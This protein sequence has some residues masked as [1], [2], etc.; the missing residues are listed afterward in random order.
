MLKG[1]VILST[2]NFQAAIRRG[3]RLGSMFVVKQLTETGKEMVERGVN[4]QCDEI[5][6]ASNK[7]NLLNDLHIFCNNENYFGGIRLAVLRGKIQPEQIEI[8][9]FHPD[10]SCEQI[11]IDKNAR[12]ASMPI[13][14]FDASEEVL[15]ELIADAK[16]N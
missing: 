1:K 9:F 10:G 2:G 15:L 7:L 4:L 11:Y 5:K 12:F 6:Y 3:S 16:T 13:G 8:F 14:F